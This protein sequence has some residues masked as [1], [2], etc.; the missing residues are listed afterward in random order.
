MPPDLL[1][2]DL[3]GIWVVSLC[4]P[5]DGAGDQHLILDADLW[6]R[7]KEQELCQNTDNY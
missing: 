1:S 2:W 6:G 3:N 4:P 7:Q 5:L